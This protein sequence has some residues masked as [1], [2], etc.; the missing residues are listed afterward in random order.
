MINIKAA[1][2]IFLRACFFMQIVHIIIISSVELFHGGCQH[3]SIKIGIFYY[4]FTIANLIG[5]FCYIYEKNFAPVFLRKIYFSISILWWIYHYFFVYDDFFP[6]NSDLLF[7]SV[8][9]VVN[10]LDIINYTV[11]YLYASQLK[12]A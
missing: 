9:V 10:V 2:N 4:S 7:W 3:A 8:F 6:N 5:F 11:L 1:A 12:R